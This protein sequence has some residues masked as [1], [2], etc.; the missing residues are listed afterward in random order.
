M[1]TLRKVYD[2]NRKAL[3]AVHYKKIVYADRQRW[4]N[5]DLLSTG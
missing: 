2:Y 1:Q 4:K 5:P 3:W